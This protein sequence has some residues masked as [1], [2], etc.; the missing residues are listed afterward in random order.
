M[1]TNKEKENEKR[2]REERKKKWKK[3]KWGREFS[4]GVYI[5]I[6]QITMKRGLHNLKSRR[7]QTTTEKVKRQRHKK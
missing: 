5:C 7:K 4:I 6:L 3:E 1:V 2:K